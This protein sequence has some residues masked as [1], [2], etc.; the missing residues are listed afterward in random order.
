[1]PR[2]RTTSERVVARLLGEFDSI[3]G[4]GQPISIA[5]HVA[6]GGRRVVIV[7]V[8]NE[9]QLSHTLHLDAEATKHAEPDHHKSARHDEGANDDVADGAAAGNL[10][11]EEAHERRPRDPPAPVKD[12]PPVHEF[13]GAFFVKRHWSV[14]HFV[15]VFCEA[16]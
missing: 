6:V 5:E 16:I 4:D 11:D 1:V 9:H 10:G 3:F 15:V 13:N 8:H 2:I 12:R 7:R 14:F